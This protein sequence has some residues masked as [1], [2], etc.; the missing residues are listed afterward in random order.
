M[1]QKTSNGIGLAFQD[2]V[3][4]A[5][6]MRL[7]AVVGVDGKLV[8]RHRQISIGVLLIGGTV[9]R[10]MAVEHTEPDTAGDVQ[11]PGQRE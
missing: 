8:S 11:L 9:D 4:K 7:L 1:N 2:G 5:A 6:G 3:E 10:E